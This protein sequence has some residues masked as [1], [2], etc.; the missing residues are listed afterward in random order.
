MGVSCLPDVN[1]LVRP[2]HRRHRFGFAA[3]RVKPRHVRFDRSLK[4]RPERFGDALF[5]RR[6]VVGYVNGDCG[7]NRALNDGVEPYCHADLAVVHRC[8]GE[9]VG[10]RALHRIVVAQAFYRGGGDAGLFLLCAFGRW[11]RTRG[12]WSGVLCRCRP[13]A[14]CHDRWYFLAWGH[15]HWCLKRPLYRVCHLDLRAIFAQ[16]R[17]GRCGL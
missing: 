5:P 17:S 15:A 4:P 7:V 13:S 9:H 10:R 3:H 11:L 16:P 8:G 6:F 14:S 2:A 12:D 1:E